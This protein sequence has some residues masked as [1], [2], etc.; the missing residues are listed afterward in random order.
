V[1]YL[2]INQRSD[3]NISPRK[4]NFMCIIII[5]QK[6]NSVPMEILK[7]S[8]R[9]NPH[10]LGIVWLD[11][12]SVSYHKSKDYNLLNTTRPFIAHFRYATVGEVN[13][14]NTHPFVC[15][16]NSDELL[17]MNGTIKNLGNT[18]MCDSKVLA[19]AL[20]KIPRHTWK[21]ELEKYDSRFVSINTRTRSFQIY[22]R[23]KYIYRDGV[24]YS[25]ENVLQDNLVAVYGTLKKGYSNYN[26]LLRSSNHIASGVTAKKYPL[27][28]KGLPYLMEEEGKGYNVEVDVFSVSKNTLRDLDSLEGHPKFYERKM[29]K[30]VSKGKSFDC[31]IYFNRTHNSLGEVFHSTYTQEPL[32]SWV[33]EEENIIKT[34]CNQ[35]IFDEVATEDESPMCIGCYTDLEYDGF[36]NYH[37]NQCDEWYAES[38]VTQFNTF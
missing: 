16:N 24:W 32:R 6:Q 38:E 26:R 35:F 20:G 22:N 11:T 3:S 10:G 18:K 34:S 33:H 21:Q 37:C 1:L 29:T 17:M 27:V 2:C 4:S 30:I 7:N 13:R 14:E 25:K 36:N 31:W 5:K 12:Y 28:I 8:A 9:I 23:N 19:N 15:G